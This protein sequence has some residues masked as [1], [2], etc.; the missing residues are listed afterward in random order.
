MITARISRAEMFMRMAEVAALRS[1]CQ[2]N[3]VGCVITDVEGMTVLAIGYNG[4][5][6]GLPNKCD[7][8]EPGECGCIHA[9]VNALIKAPFHQGNLMLYSTASPCVDCAKL[10]LNSRI[11]AVYYRTEYR[12]LEGV[13]LLNDHKI[14][15]MPLMQELE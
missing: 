12:L 13:H 15:C 8:T 3:R 9:E 10:I 1:T 14:H 11:R 6:R 5:A 7:S 2:R 4:N